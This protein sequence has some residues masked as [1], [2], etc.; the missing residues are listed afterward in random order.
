MINE[1]R[2]ID[3]EVRI[4]RQDDLVDTLNT[5]VYRQQKKIDDLEALCLALAGRL[6]EL[7]V[8][9]SQRTAVMDERPPHY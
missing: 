6:R 5:Q 7:A 8:S 3:L 9:A 2:L 4:A 1:E